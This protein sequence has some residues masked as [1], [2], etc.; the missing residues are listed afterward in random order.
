MLRPASKRIVTSASSI[1]LWAS[2]FLPHEAASDPQR[3]SAGNFGLP[4]II[5]LPTAHHF[6]DAELVVLNSAQIFSA[7]RHF[8]STL[9]ACF[10]IQGMA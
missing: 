5:D 8:F 9:W 2:L 7:F 1:F 3:S 6:P 10:A 4:G